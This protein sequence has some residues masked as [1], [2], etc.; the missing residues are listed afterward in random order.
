MTYN[1]RDESNWLDFEKFKELYLKKPVNEHSNNVITEI[2][3]PV[4]SVRL[5]TYNQADYIRQSIESIL[6][7]ETNFPFEILLGDDGSNDGTQEICF[8][9]AESNPDKIRFF[10]NSRENNILIHGRPNHLFQYG[11]FTFH[12]RGQYL[13]SCAGDDYWTDK[14]KLQ[15]QVDYLEDNTQFS[16]VCTNYSIVNEKNEVIKED[17]WGKI[18]KNGS[19][20]HLT[21]LRDFK[22]KTQTALTRCSAIPEKLPIELFQSLNEDNFFCAFIS[23]KNDVGYMDYVSTAY[24]VHSNSIWSSIDEIAQKQ[25]QLNTYLN[26]SKV[27]IN[28]EQN[29]AI[30]ARIGRIRRK[31]SLGYAE[32][33]SLLKAY[34]EA[35]N[36]ISHGGLYFLKH[37]LRLNFRIIKNLFS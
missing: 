32:E 6:M 26:M 22:P 2:P 30:N 19:I 15:K 13:A 33:G 10:S 35:I 4:V 18:I 12:I 7:Q 25:M 17:G 29:I 1:K 8:E 36:L 21:I 11:Y 9:Y 3:E 16:M 31:L 27:F 34:K 20:D 28:K 14:F 23:E 37:F 5:I 24:R